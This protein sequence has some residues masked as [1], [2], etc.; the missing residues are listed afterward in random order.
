MFE[1]TFVDGEAKT[2]RPATIMLSLLLQLP[3]DRRADSDSV[4]LLR[5]A[6]DGAVEAACWCASAA[7]S[8]A[9]A[10]AAAPPVKVVKLV[11]RAV[12]SPTS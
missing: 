9:A 6:A 5:S 8:S 4:D 3:G 12:R 7:A 10:A 11:P 2:K 1:Q